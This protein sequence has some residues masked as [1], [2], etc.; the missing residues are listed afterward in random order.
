MQTTTR[1]VSADGVFVCSLRPPKPGTQVSLKLYLP[2]APHAEE[3]TAVVREW[4]S[5]PESGYWAD[6][7]RPPQVRFGVAQAPVYVQRFCQ[8]ELHFAARVNH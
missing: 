4:R 6:F 8:R 7:E 2:G 1:E 3:V 5:A